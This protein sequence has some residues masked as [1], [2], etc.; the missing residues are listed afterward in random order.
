MTKIWR[1]KAKSVPSSS[2]K[3]QERITCETTNKQMTNLSI[4]SPHQVETASEHREETMKIEEVPDTPRQPTLCVSPKPV[5]TIGKD[6]EIATNDIEFQELCSMQQAFKSIKN[7]NYLKPGSEIE[8]LTITQDFLKEF[9]NVHSKQKLQLIIA[10]MKFHAE[11][12]RMALLKLHRAIEEE[13]NGDPL[14]QFFQWIT[15]NYEMSKRQKMIL[16]QKAIEN[17]K[18]D[19]QSNPADEIELAI[20]E[21]QLTVGEITEN[22]FLS[23]L[24]KE[25]L[26]NCMPSAY[27]LK[28]V[29]MNIAEMLQKIPE[30]WKEYGSHEITF[31]S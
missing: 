31:Q 28:I 9:P 30:I 3:I 16:L 7:W 17:N 10:L 1:H 26:R 8:W 12:K 27:Y 14:E 23:N 25:I 13:E 6:D 20:R 18:F 2:K 5:S 19:W 22:Q 11:A 21:A 15:V 29:G 4:N 24:M